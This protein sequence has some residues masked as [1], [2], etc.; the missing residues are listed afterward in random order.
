MWVIQPEGY[1]WF[2]AKGWIGADMKLSE[3]LGENV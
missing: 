1:C 2:K 3:E